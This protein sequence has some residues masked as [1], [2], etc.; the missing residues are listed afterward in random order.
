MKN[1]DRKK[2]KKAE[3][4]TEAEEM[5]AHG[6]T[7]TT[8]EYYCIGKYRYTNLEGAVAQAQRAARDG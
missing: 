3:F 6:I 1:V 7:K 4:I 8:I 5:A 2:P